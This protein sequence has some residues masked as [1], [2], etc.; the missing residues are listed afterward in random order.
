MSWL[1]IVLIN[2]LVVS[3]GSLFQRLAMK[4]KS[5]DAVV[6]T[7]IYQLVLGILVLPYALTQG[8]VFPPLLQLWPYFLL[9]A[10]LYG[11]GSVLF[12]KSIKLI[13]ASEMIV[14]SAFGAV[15]TMFCAYL[16]LGER[17]VWMQYVGCLLVLLAILLIASRG[18]KI[19]FGR[20]AIFALLATSFFSFAVISDMVIIRSYDAV[21]FAATMSILPGLALLVFYPRQALQLPQAVRRVDKNLIFYTL[22]YSVAVV[23]FYGALGMGALVSQVSVVT[24]ANIILTVLLAAIFLKER[25]GL[26]RKI[27]AAI[28]CTIGVVLV[29]L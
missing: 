27:G 11:F 4:E 29:A 3:L 22:L 19:T 24:K 14:L 6:S 28:L 5:S 26:G 8:F 2:V 13:E 21:S 25:D 20:G 10:I 16:F 23:T 1:V 7:I 18:S 12:F 17:L 15:V 9:S